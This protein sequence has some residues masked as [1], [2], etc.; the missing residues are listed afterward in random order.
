[1]ANAQESQSAVPLLGQRIQELAGELRTLKARSE[2]DL[3]TARAN[4][5]FLIP[6][7]SRLTIGGAQPDVPLYTGPIR[8]RLNSTSLAGIAAVLQFTS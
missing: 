8:A 3:K 1:M 6:A 4:A 2:E 5:D 7:N